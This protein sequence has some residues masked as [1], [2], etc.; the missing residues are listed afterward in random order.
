MPT[1]TPRWAPDM[2]GR[3]IMRLPRRWPTT[4]VYVAGVTVL[5]LL[6]CWS[7]TAR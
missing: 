5:F 6:L 3:D 2:E 4:T 1:M 7:G